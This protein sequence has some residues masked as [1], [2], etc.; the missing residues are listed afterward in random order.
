[1]KFLHVR[2]ATSIITYGG[3]KFLTD[4][5][6]S[7][8]GVAPA[9]P[10]TPCKRKNPLVGLSTSVD[11]LVNADVV[12]ST[13]SHLDHFDQKAVEL[14]KKDMP[15]ICQDIDEKVF[16]D[17]GFN[18][19]IPADKTIEYKGIK[20]T[21]VKAQH[22]EG[23]IEKLMGIASGYI[24]SAANEPIVYIAGDTIYNDS[25][26]SNIEK[27]KPEIVVLNAGSPKFLNSGQIVMNIIDV[28]KTLE[29]NPKLKFIIVHLDTFNHCIETREDMR[30]YF[31]EDKLK[32]M[33]VENFFIPEDNETL[34]F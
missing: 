33:E 5:I 27:Y 21:R 31:N 18:N 6:L 15:I 16:N 19:I 24:L 14:L 2:H 10:M 9:I 26:K 13:H 7:D 8:K 20:I 11:T 12:L 3:I 17:Y 28:E 32:A 23:E 1:M 25:V 34:E 30:E 22:G 29:I 4:P